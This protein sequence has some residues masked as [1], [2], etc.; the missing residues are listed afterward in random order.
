[1]DRLRGAT[2]RSLGLNGGRTALADLRRFS[3]RVD[4]TKR[5][6]DALQRSARVGLDTIAEHARAL[7]DARREDYD[8]ARSLLKLPSFNA[9]DIGPGLLG[10]VTIEAVEKAMVWVNLGRR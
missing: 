4:S 1:A 8:L 9:P 10:N 2:P 5:A 7:D 6:V 3:A